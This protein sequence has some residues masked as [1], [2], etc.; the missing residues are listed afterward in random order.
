MLATIIHKP[1]TTPLHSPKYISSD[2]IPVLEY[3]QAF[4][5][6]SSLPFQQIK[7]SVPRLWVMR[8]LGVFFF[9]LLTRHVWTGGRMGEV[10]MM[11]CLRAVPIRDGVVTEGRLGWGAMKENRIHLHRGNILKQITYFSGIGRE[12]EEGEK[13]RNAGW[14]IERREKEREGVGN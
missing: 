3:I 7:Q 9:F 12:G 13:S 2:S 8:N 11:V 1:P 10:C 4:H 14:M 5:S 6:G